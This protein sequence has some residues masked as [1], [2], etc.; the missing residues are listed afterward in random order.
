MRTPSFCLVAVLLILSSTSVSG[1]ENPFRVQYM[2]PPAD[3]VMGRNARLELGSSKL[4][5]ELLS[6]TGDSLWVLSNGAVLGFPLQ[7]LGTIDV[8]MHKWGSSRLWKW[9]LVA[10]LGSALA[11][12]AACSSVEG[13]DGCGGF[14]LGWSAI[15]TLI[16]GATGYA[17]AATSHRKVHPSFEALR[18]WVRY[19]QGPPDKIRPGGGS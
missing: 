14:F 1:Q 9:N 8:Q 16:G 10:G 6:V 2:P 13:T 7:E 15:W 5:G 19:P 18:P 3:V 12:T 11:L 4:Q 17:L